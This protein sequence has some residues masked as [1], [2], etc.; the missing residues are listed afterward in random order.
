MRTARAA[1]ACATALAL[2]ALLVSGGS[3]ADPRTPPALPGLPPP[4]LGT[5]VSG[6]GG[7]TAAVDAYGDVVDLRAP[8]PAGTA[9]I[10]N[11]S[12]RQAA[13][14]VPADTG[15]VP[16]VRIA[17]G[18]P[19]PM[20]RAD[21]VAQR[22]LTGTNVVRTAARFRG[23][24]VTI[25]TA[26]SGDSLAMRIEARST[27]RRGAGGRG[28]PGRTTGAA[29]ARAA[30]V[31]AVAVDASAG[32]RCRREGGGGRLD[33]LCGVGRGAPFVPGTRA[34]D[35]GR[36]SRGRT[37]QAGGGS[38]AAAC[39]RL[40]RSAAQEA[41]HWLGRSR[42]LGVGPRGAR[43]GSWEPRPGSRGARTG[44]WEP[45]PGSR[46]AQAGA[47]AAPAWARRMYRRSLL[48][49]H[50]LTSRATGAVAAGAR[51]GW[52]HVWPRD[53]ATA[54]IALAATDH[55]G[56]ARS[57]AR[58]LDG[59]DLGAAARFAET[60]APVPGRAAQGDAAS[61]V[62]AAARAAGLPPTSAPLPWRDRADYQE[63]EPGTYLGNALA[64]ASLP[65]A[66]RV[67]E[68]STSGGAEPVRRGPTAGQGH[69]STAGAA[70]IAGEFGTRRGL[71]RSA[72]APG[73]GLDSAAAWAVRPFRLTSL[74][75]A[76]EATLLSLARHGTRYGITPGEG[77]AGGE[78]PW[79]APTAWTAWALAALPGRD[80]GA[81]ANPRG[82][83]ASGPRPNLHA[84]RED[85]AHSRRSPQA[86]DRAAADRRAALA[87][88]SDLRRAATPAGDLPERVG[89]RTGIPTSTTPLLWSSALSVLA[90]RELWP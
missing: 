32:L 33:L 79:S 76:A 46:G 70:R 48:T 9:L 69:G 40:I 44:A 3:G 66:H 53:A 82:T 56:E 67:G 74:Y 58:F 90:L 1:L 8:G 37:A 89:V 29:E 11:P 30:A 39:A 34:G 73:S 61:W 59:L 68:R 64:A 38:V 83:G 71:V 12:R 80:G 17:G 24:R 6:D 65:R 13:G 57:V 15:I 75:P 20:W 47:R 54:A 60:G 87:L 72:G 78:D 86:A 21:S 85:E 5:A 26:A 52:A 25:T 19:L 10:D 14:T 36:P 63:S 16:R 55:R 81:G 84:V 42:S 28:A 77:W 22:Y 50:A 4:F 41:R 7:L 62:D 51:D 49:I 18:R 27:A 88:L 43:T 23:A 35:R 45:R 2:G 31:P